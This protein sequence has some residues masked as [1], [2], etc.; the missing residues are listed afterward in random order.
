MMN[1]LKRDELE[2]LRSAVEDQ[3]LN[4]RV[5]MSAIHY[6][7]RALR[8]RQQYADSLKDDEFRADQLVSEDDLLLGIV[9]R[10][11]KDHEGELMQSFNASKQVLQTID[12]ILK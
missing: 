9:E 5:D 10:Y 3:Y 11:L 4:T 2:R 1:D 8:G 6:V 7:K 12:E